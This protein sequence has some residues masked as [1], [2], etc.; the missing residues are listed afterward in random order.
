MAKQNRQLNRFEKYSIIL[1]RYCDADSLSVP[2]TEVLTRKAASRLIGRGINRLDLFLGLDKRIVRNFFSTVDLLK[3]AVNSLKSYGQRTIP[4]IMDSYRVGQSHYL[5][6]PFDVLASIIDHI[7]NNEIDYSF[8]KYH[9]VKNALDIIGVI[10]YQDL[11]DAGIAKVGHIKGFGKKGFAE[12]AKIIYG[13]KA[14]IEDPQSAMKKKATKTIKPKVEDQSSSQKAPFDISILKN[15]PKVKLIHIN[16]VKRINTRLSKLAAKGETAFLN[17][18]LKDAGASPHCYSFASKKGLN[19]LMDVYGSLDKIVKRY[20]YVQCRLKNLADNIVKICDPVLKGSMSAKPKDGI[21]EAPKKKSKISSSTRSK[22]SE[23]AGDNC[24]LCIKINEMRKMTE[25]DF[26][27]L[28]KKQYR[29]IC[30]FKLTPE[31]VR[32]WKDEYRQFIDCFIPAFRKHDA[33][34]L[35]FYVVFELKLPKFRTDI[36]S[37][38]FIYADAVILGNEGVVVLEFKQREMVVVEQ[39]SSQALKYMKRL[40]YHRLVGRQPHKYT[41]L[42]YTKEKENHLDVLGKH[43]NFWYGNPKAVASDICTR[44]F[45]AESPYLDTD[46]WLNAGFKEKRSHKTRHK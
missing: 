1:R 20:G 32:S 34:T 45:N 29:N 2:I 38:E 41:Y 5:I 36:E 12:L 23:R 27:S 31:R 24:C 8:T 14:R 6:E 22:I 15:D 21:K 3:S 44:F 26:V 30:K 16:A 13:E 39:F 42:V 17:K 7:A 28:M 11:L 35:S 10:T 18:S 19:T 4:T 37:D 25:T 9:S 33:N 43:K 46:E 40:R